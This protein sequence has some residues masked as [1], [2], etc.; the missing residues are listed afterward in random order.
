MVVDRPGLSKGEMTVA[1]GLWELGTATVRQVHERIVNEQEMDIATVQTYL[2]RL[3]TKGYASSVLEGRTRVY[4]PRAKA[5][6]VIRSTVDDLVARLFGGQTMPLVRH[7]IEESDLDAKD[8]VE[9]RQL[10]DRMQ[11]SEP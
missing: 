11:G 7:L 10:I 2:R 1:S 3:E 9:L 8:L 5:K 6:T 4:K